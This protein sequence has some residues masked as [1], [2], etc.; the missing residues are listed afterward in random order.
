MHKSRQR[1]LHMY[2]IE[3]SATCRKVKENR[4]SGSYPKFENSNK[5][6]VSLWASSTRENQYSSKSI[7]GNIQIWLLFFVHYVQIKWWDSWP[8]LSS[9]LRNIKFMGQ[10]LRGD[11]NIRCC[12][13]LLLLCYWRL[14][15]HLTEESALPWKMLN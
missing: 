3:F 7:K 11:Q 10:L 5:I 12:S 4:S 14:C 9:L 13:E 1:L 6:Q 8:S 2:T 15:L